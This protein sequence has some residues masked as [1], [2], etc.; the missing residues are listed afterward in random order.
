MDASSHLAHVSQYQNYQGSTS[1]PSM[2]RSQTTGSTG[3]N[4][5]DFSIPDVRPG[6]ARIGRRLTEM[7]ENFL[8]DDVKSSDSETKRPSTPS[9]STSVPFMGDEPV[10]CP[11]CDKPLPPA[12]LLQHMT[13]APDSVPNIKANPRLAG[14]ESSSM[15]KTTSAP[16][17]SGSAKQ[18]STP[19]GKPH[20]NKQPSGISASRPTSPMSAA[21]LAANVKEADSVD[22]AAGKL[23]LDTDTLRKWSKIAGVELD[24]PAPTPEVSA[25]K[26]EDTQPQTPAK[27]FPK[28]APP[29]EDSSRSSSRNSSKFS[30]FGKGKNKPEDDEDDESDDD[31]GGG[32]GYAR[33]DAPASPERVERELPSLK[34]RSVEEGDAS[35]A[36]ETSTETG[37]ETKEKAEPVASDAEVR[38]LLKEVLIKIN[39]VVRSL[40]SPSAS[41]DQAWL[42]SHSPN[43]TPRF[44]IPTV[45]YSLRSRLLA[46]TWQWLRPTRKCS[47]NS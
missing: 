30:L 7:S 38:E 35:V 20:L 44:Y 3:P 37:Q 45:P 16:E 23:L 22:S 12:L 29:P 43:H 26:K 10:F 27:P 15:A 6:L 21:Q 19:A 8:Y 28:L 9:M 2:S 36:T 40:D 46:P 39:E 33:L 11:F 14:V 4:E 13:S 34:K 32:G 42:T 18:P 47:R 41:E 31:L 1:R 25:S 5:I 24:L 17:G